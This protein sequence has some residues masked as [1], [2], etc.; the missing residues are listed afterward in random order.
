MDFSFSQQ[1]DD[2]RNAT[3]AFGVGLDN[4]N[5]HVR[6][7]ALATQ[8][9][10]GLLIPETFGG[11]GF[12]ALDAALALEALAEGCDDGGLCFSLAAHLYAGLVPL[13][14]AG[15]AEQKKQFLPAILSGD[16]IVANAM[17]EAASGSDAFSLR[18]TATLKNDRYLLN[19]SKVFVTNAPV[20]NLLVVYALTDPAKGFFG[21]I[22]AF[23]LEKGKHNYRVG[24]TIDK[25]GLDT[26]PLAEVFFDE[27]EVDA[28]CVLGKPGGGAL[29]FQQSMN[30]ERSGIALMHCGTMQRLL[31]LSIDYAKQREISGQPIASHQAVAFRIADMQVR[32][33]AARLL[34]CRAN[35]DLD[36][37]TDATRSSAQAKIFSSEALAQTAQDA[38]LLHGGNGFTKAYPVEHVLRDAQ[39]AL[40]Y[41]GTNDVLRNLVGKL[42]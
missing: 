11:A 4:G 34:A 36:Q 8:G 28:S 15:N 39:G 18:T 12:G 22:T 30:Y 38:L 20:A 9:L 29:I 21:G 24:L 25:L 5:F 10:T 40:I 37:K 3:R 41:S 26:S 42:L 17:T 13:L 7:R 33:Q 31:N 1:Q 16:D 6:W 27:V 23:L 14:H 2:F 32:L 19:G 35:A